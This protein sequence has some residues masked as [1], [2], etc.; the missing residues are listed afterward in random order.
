MPDLK[1]G[2]EQTD[3]AG[4]TQHFNGTM[5]TSSAPIPLVA[6]NVISE[7]FFNVPAQGGSSNDEGQISLDGGI[8]FISFRKGDG[9]A[10]SIKGD[11]RQVF[12][13]SNSGNVDYQIILNFED[14]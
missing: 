4:S 10:F 13:K 12:V 11:I 5:N 6:G 9:F 3:K 2:F 1:E 8:N 7:F 14:Y